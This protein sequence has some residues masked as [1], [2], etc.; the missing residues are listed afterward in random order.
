MNIAMIT[1]EAV[2][3]SKTGG[4]ADALGGLY[5][6]LT[7]RGHTVKVFTPLYR[8]IMEGEHNI[9]DTGD[10]VAVGLGNEKFEVKVLREGDYFFI[11]EDT[12]FDREEF[13]GHGESAYEDNAIRF[14]LF[15]MASL[16][17]LKMLGESV[18]IIHC[19]DWQTGLVPLYL[20][21]D[22]DG[23]GILG[24]A[25]SVFTIHN[26]AYQGLFPKDTIDTLGLPQKL[27]NHRELE[28][29]GRLSFI[30]GGLVFADILTTVSKKYSREIQ[31]APT[32]CGLEGVLRER[33]K[34]LFGVINGIDADSW[35]PETDRVIPANYGVGDLT[36]KRVC[37]EALKKAFD[38]PDNGDMPLV[39]MVSRLDPQKGFKIIEEA[40]KSLMKLPIQM[41]FLG[42]GSEKIEDYLTG[43]AKRHPGKVG[44]SIGYNDNLAHLVEAGSDMYL[45]PSKYE[46]CGLNHLY[47]LRYG[48]IPIVRATG[49][50]DDTITNYKAGSRKGNGF[51]FGNFTARAMV[52][53]MTRAVELYMKDRQ[54]WSQLQV[55]A[56]EENHSWERSAISYEKIYEKALR[57]KLSTGNKRKGARR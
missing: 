2:P 53:A 39:G 52:R 31:E 3:Y 48:T 23:D 15:S 47:S 41:V 44:V 1:S 16:E 10:R 34:D 6:E 33:K 8:G 13:Y 9:N 30:K 20:K 7:R 45:M 49:G 38:L 4:L 40:E 50:L 32:G 54:A 29:F 51:K 26:L 12:L 14:A 22:Y 57:K 19:H 5:K 43:L 25:A 28:F 27:F 24:R 21:K 17:A 37:K 18:D 55:S 36:G 46:P 56:M 11:R 42:S 35:S